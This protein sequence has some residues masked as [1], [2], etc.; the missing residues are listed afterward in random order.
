M[1]GV[2]VF[3]FFGV[4][5]GV[6]KLPIDDFI[7]VAVANTNVFSTAHSASKNELVFDDGNCRRTT[8]RSAK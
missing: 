1:N 3:E 5:V 6:W 2:A 8:R 7:A 4:V